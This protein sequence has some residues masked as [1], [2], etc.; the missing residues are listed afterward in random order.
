MGFI[1]PTI[2]MAALITENLLDNEKNPTSAQNAPIR[3]FI[4][5]ELNQIIVYGL[6]PHLTGARP[7]PT[8][9]PQGF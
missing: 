2:E 8:H 6:S 7:I 5:L 9:G 1:V 4:Y 3:I